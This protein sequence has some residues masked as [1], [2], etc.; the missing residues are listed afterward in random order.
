[1]ITTAQDGYRVAPGVLVD[2]AYRCAVKHWN[3]A[4]VDPFIP[5]GIAL[6]VYFVA[7]V[8]ESRWIVICLFCGGAQLAARDDPRFFCVD[9]LNEAVKGQ[10]VG[11]R[12]PDDPA[13][14]EALLEVR[15]DPASRSWLP[16]ETLEDLVA[17]NVAHNLPADLP[18]LT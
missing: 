5:S 18:G 3:R 13:A 8:N 4:D 6:D 10:W 15:P 11:V 2:D 7:Q 16:H 9:C 12:W 1:V 17:Q 14:I